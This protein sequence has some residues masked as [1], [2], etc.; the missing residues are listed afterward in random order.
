M[1]PRVST[2]SRVVDSSRAFREG[3]R[4][5][6]GPAPR[7]ARLNKQLGDLETLRFDPAGRDFDR[8]HLPFITVKNKCMNFLRLHGKCKAENIQ[9]IEK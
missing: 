8:R 3:A 7:S 2:A 9:E 1:E 6:P 4:S 5:L